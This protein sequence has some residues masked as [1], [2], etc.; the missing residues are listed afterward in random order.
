VFF[1]WYVHPPVLDLIEQQAK[2]LYRLFESARTWEESPY[3]NIFG[4]ANSETIDILRQY[5]KNYSTYGENKKNYRRSTSTYPHEWWTYGTFDSEVGS[6]L[7]PKFLNPLFGIS[8]GSPDKLR[9]DKRGTPLAPFHLNGQNASRWKT[10]AKSKLETWCETFIKIAKEGS[11]RLRIRFLVA[12]DLAFCTA[13]LDPSE[14]I[15]ED[16]GFYCRPWTTTRLQ[17]DGAD[18]SCTARNAAPRKFNVIHSNHLVESV[19]LLNLLPRIGSL[20]ENTTSVVYTTLPSVEGVEEKNLLEYLL[21]G[22]VSV[23]CYLLSLA[24]TT[25][26]SG[27]SIVPPNN[28][29]ADLPAF[30]TRVGLV[31][32]RMGRSG[33][34]I[35]DLLATLP[36]ASQ[37][38]LGKLFYHIYLN[39]FG[40]NPDE[41]ILV[42]KRLYTPAAFA[43]FLGSIKK[44]LTVSMQDSIH[45]F[46]HLLSEDLDRLGEP[47]RHHLQELLLQF[48]LHKIAD[49]PLPLPVRSE[50]SFPCGVLRRQNPPTVSALVLSVPH[51][52]WSPIFEGLATLKNPPPITFQLGLVT[53]GGAHIF[54]AVQPVFGKVKTTTDGETGTIEVDPAGWR[55]KSDLILSSYFPTPILKVFKD[56]DPKVAAMLTPDPQFSD[57]FR[58][59]FG[60]DFIDRLAYCYESTVVLNISCLRHGGESVHFFRGAPHL[61]APKLSKIHSEIPIIPRRLGTPDVS[62]SYPHLD[63]ENA[64]LTTTL[65]ITGKTLILLKTGVKLEIHQLSNCTLLV[66]FG[67]NKT[68]ISFAFPVDSQR[69]KVKVSR[70]KGWIKVTAPLITPSSRG[71]LMSRPFSLVRGQDLKIYSFNLPYVNPQRFIPLDSFASSKFLIDPEELDRLISSHLETMFGPH[72]RD[73]GI[74][75]ESSK[76]RFQKSLSEMQA[77]GPSEIFVRDTLEGFVDPKAPAITF[78]KALFAT[79]LSPKTKSVYLLCSGELDA[80]ITFLVA[81]HYYDENLQTIV[82]D[83]YVS[84]IHLPEADGAIGLRIP[85]EAVYILRDMFPALQQRIPA[86]WE[87]NMN[88]CEYFM[89]DIVPPS[90]DYDSGLCDCGKGKVEKDFND[91]KHWKNYRRWMTRILISPLFP[92]PYLPS[93]LGSTPSTSSAGMS[94]TMPAAPQTEPPEQKNGSGNCEQGNSVC[95]VCAKEASKRC[96]KC[97]VMYCSRECQV[98]D[99]KVHKPSCVGKA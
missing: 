29:H 86:K 39:M 82:A 28:F 89:P 27:V 22:N 64:T 99:W 34:A 65:T 6:R 66:Y 74:T 90:D 10:M 58:E 43:Y 5:W 56:P 59:L 88:T 19:G 92:V 8:D 2:K 38:D 87:H 76:E 75:P 20:M 41:K 94:T 78:I 98:Q 97:T 49:E 25:F 1:D 3:G 35:M 71:F 14:G 91:V 84:I 77:H 32:W 30:P 48:L 47:G 45:E 4:I 40:L 69:T 37:Q 31:A 81:G 17:L 79:L 93:T 16:T 60:S 36:T 62:I 55:G 50:V 44:R 15:H 61:K 12:D 52:Q 46:L 72:E 11:N 70:V 33:D 95:A 51:F 23:M 9:L 21:C 54:S 53:R 80:M 26:L 57:T 96:A 73:N 67:S 83:T 7:V 63:V 68:H 24:P 13:L 85:Q 18:Y 42:N